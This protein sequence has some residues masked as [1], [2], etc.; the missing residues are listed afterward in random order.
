MKAFSQFI[1]E[2][3]SEDIVPL[4]PDEAAKEKSLL[5]NKGKKGTL[6]NQSGS[7]KGI[8]PKEVNRRLSASTT[9]GDQARK[10]YNTSGIQGDSNTGGNTPS[11]DFSNTPS[12]NPTSAPKNSNKVN[13]NNRPPTFAEVEASATKT[14]Q[15]RKA[16][17]DAIKGGANNTPSTASKKNGVLDKLYKGAEKGKQRSKDG[18]KNLIDRVKGNGDPRVP[19][20]KKGELGRLYKSNDTVADPKR[21]GSVRTTDKINTEL[22]AKRKAR[23]N[24]KTGK[25]TKKGVEN[26]AI[27]QQTKGL[28]TKGD[29]GKK[30]VTKAKEIASDA[31]SKAYKDIAN[32]INTSDYAGKRAK[33]ASA[34]ELKKINSD[35]KKS[36]TINQK[37]GRL[38]IPRTNKQINTATK[39]GRI[40]SK[41]LPTS[42]P[43][44]ST[45]TPTPT[46]KTSTPTPTPKTSTPQ[47]E[48]P[49]KSSK[50]STTATK[51]GIRSNTIIPDWEK[52]KD[53]VRSNTSTSTP[54]PKTSTIQMGAKGGKPYS[55]FIKTAKKTKPASAIKNLGGKALG[56]GF[57]AWNAID[58]YNAAR[59][60]GRSVAGSLVK[61]A[62]TTGAYY[63]GATAG[64][65]IAAPIPVPGARIVG[66][67]AGGN[68]AS[69]VAT[70]TYD[71]L[72]KVKKKDKKVGGAIPGGTGKKK[73]YT[74]SSGIA[75]ESGP[76]K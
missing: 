51:T 30:A 37:G 73:G 10:Q 76:K 52:V 12:T 16:Q 5:R 58:N 68:T 64:A 55:E 65:A 35:I 33:L 61:S 47:I 26:F 41:G 23:I 75:I 13:P 66:G 70:K 29:A 8:D 71:K 7:T 49:W 40:I 24:P 31:R 15:G 22:T 32:K 69:N 57:V 1:I 59:A 36:K 25:A 9:K 46:P 21:A 6:A 45:P 54:T 53:R 39:Q 72:F 50:S 14:P 27:N 60:Q 44:T 67:L 17:N 3:K 38:T 18:L 43:K 19:D 62:V 42:T 34:D 48:D 2:K 56:T 74:W 11:K 20:P 63:G 4:K 28:S